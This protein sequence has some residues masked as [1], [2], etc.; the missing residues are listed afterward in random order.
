MNLLDIALQ[1]MAIETSPLCSLYSF[2]F[3]IYGKSNFGT[4]GY[5]W[6]YRSF[7]AL[8]I[9]QG[10]NIKE[11]FQK[12]VKGTVST[13]FSPVFHDSNTYG[14][15]I[16]LLKVFHIQYGLNFVEIFARPKNSAM[17]LTPRSLYHQHLGVSYIINTV[18]ST[19]S[20]PPWRQLYHY[21][22]GVRYVIN[23]V[24]SDISLTPWS[25]LYH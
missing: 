15:L 3:P 14:S 1:N 10:K 25:Q 11:I 22:R 17:S 16:Y 6:I 12:F 21:H 7:P 20:L 5:R 9:Q 18:E 4:F 8:Y 24:E 19:I 2:V 13:D 23:T